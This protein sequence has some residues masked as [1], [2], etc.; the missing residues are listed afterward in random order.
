MTRKPHAARSILFD[1][2]APLY[3][4][5]VWFLTLPLGGENR[6]RERVVEKASPLKGL[7][8][9]EV[10]AG[11]ATLSLL[12]AEKGA[13]ATAV[14]ISAGML[15]V[16]GEKAEKSGL[17][18]RLLK[19]DASE[20][21]FVDGCYD[22]VVVSMGLHEIDA[23]R[24]PLVLKEAYRVLKDKGRL[25][26]FDYYRA[27]GWARAFQSLFFTFV[28]GETARDWVRLDLQGILSGIGFKDFKRDFLLKRSVQILTV[29][30][31]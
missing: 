1:W 19:A 8:T 12:F 22:R 13:E 15:R 10:F 21:P 31:R 20:L 26:I 24:V 3:D 9:L 17:K 4:L 27:E 25:V 7:K 2:F 5:A 30:K 29:E 14:D 28:E 18:V 11:T 23:S 6:L 16:A